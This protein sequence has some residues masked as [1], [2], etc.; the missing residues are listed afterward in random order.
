MIRLRVA[1]GFWLWLLNRLGCDGL[2]LPVF[3]IRIRPECM[4]DAELIRHEI[5]H[6]VQME[7]LGAVRFSVRYLWEFWRYGYWN[8]PLEIEARERAAKRLPYLH[9]ARTIRVCV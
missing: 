8:M 4:G 9:P 6:C 7:R 3:G 2:S 1:S 5:T